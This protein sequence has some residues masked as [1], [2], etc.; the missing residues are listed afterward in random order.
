MDEEIIKRNNNNNNKKKKKKK[1]NRLFIGSLPKDITDTEF[2]LFFGQ[3]GK[4]YEAY[5]VFHRITGNPRGFGYISYIDPKV[6][7]HVLALGLKENEN[8]NEKGFGYGFGRIVMRGKVCE[9]KPANNKGEGGTTSTNRNRV[10]VG[11]LPPNCCDGELR[12]YFQQFGAVIDSTVSVHHDTGIS[13]GFGFVT[14]ADPKVSS[15]ILKIRDN[16][17]RTTI[18]SKGRDDDNGIGRIVMGGCVCVVKLFD[19]SRDRD[20]EQ[21][22]QQRKRSSPSLPLSKNGYNDD[23][24]DDDEGIDIDRPLTNKRPRYPYNEE[25]T[26]SS[27]SP[28]SMLA[29]SSKVRAKENGNKLVYIRN[30]PG[31][32]RSEQLVK[33]LKDRFKTAFQRDLNIDEHCIVR[34]A[35]DHALVECKNDCDRR[36]L[37][38]LKNR[39][40][41]GYTMELMPWSSDCEDMNNFKSAENDSSIQHY[42][43]SQ[44][45]DDIN[46]QEELDDIGLTEEK[47]A[48]HIKNVEDTFNNKLFFKFLSK[49]FESTYKHE[50][51]LIRCIVRKDLNDAVVECV[52][53]G[54]CNLLLQ[55][56]T[57]IAGCTMEFSRYVTTLSSTP[58]GVLN[59]NNMYAMYND[60]MERNKV[61]VMKY[62]R[63]K[64]NYVSKCNQLER[65]QKHS[66]SKN[67][68]NIVNNN[69]HHQFEEQKQTMMI[70][71]LK[72]QLHDS[73]RRF[74]DLTDT[75]SKQT[76]TIS[77]MMEEKR[78]I[79]QRLDDEV[80]IRH[81]V[82]KIFDEEKLELSQ[83]LDDEVSKR[84]KERSI[85]R[86]QLQEE[87]NTRKEAEK[88]A[89]VT[90]VQITTTKETK[91]EEELFL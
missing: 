75:V 13:R 61:L 88:N 50:L 79:L 70:D 84:N 36:D 45:F 85:H 12:D 41:Y 26:D 81:Q 80:T 25:N 89:A 76:S 55:L 48:I 87:V 4:L 33:I 7:E 14:F 49:K 5:V 19:Y 82:E 72:R 73:E 47:N 39:D 77:D 51:K 56:Q 34:H 43:K 20:I 35:A 65:E 16:N 63:L 46:K 30:V 57:R 64:K 74:H 60:T 9:I 1:K 83:Q 86:K 32:L 31:F 71:S 40:L 22:H 11:G 44:P 2:R 62:K 21:Q 10:F 29:L 91:K 78:E 69:N 23:D 59:D 24:D 54:D 17:N 42:G 53:E 37:L 15:S 28:S 66:N 67:S 68:N 3:F 6:T 90:A 38:R 27:P 18:N 58:N 8:E 52:H